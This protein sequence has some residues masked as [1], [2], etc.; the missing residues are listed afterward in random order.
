MIS[1]FGPC[2]DQLVEL[3]QGQILQVE[4]KEVV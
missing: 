1:F 2:I 3:I 4:E